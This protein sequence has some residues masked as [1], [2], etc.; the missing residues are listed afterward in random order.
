MLVLSRKTNQ[1]VIIE[2]PG[3]APVRVTLVEC[4]GAG[5]RAQLSFEG[6]SDISIYREEVHDLRDK[7]TNQ[8][9]R[10]KA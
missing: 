7:K 3:F 2:A 4:R 1:S 5:H 8:D 10:P 6:P 9:N